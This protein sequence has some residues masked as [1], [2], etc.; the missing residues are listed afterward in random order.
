M[1]MASTRSSFGRVALALAL[2]S[3]L[4]AIVVACKKDP[5]PPTPTEPA[6]E[7]APTPTE[8]LVLAPLVED[9]GDDADAADAADAAKRPTGPG[10]T[11]NQARARQCCNALRAEAKRMGASPEAAQLNGL[12]GMC[13]TFAMQLGPTRGGEAPELA[14]LRQMLKGRTL[15]AACSGL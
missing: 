5:P 13:D 2:A 1:S 15:P 11:T 7:P 4:P 3:A 10:M 8:T 6:P 12:A 14:P 9:A